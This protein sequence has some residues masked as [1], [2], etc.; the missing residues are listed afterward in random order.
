[1]DFSWTDAGKVVTTLLA[2]VGGGGLIIWKLSTYIGE[3]WA[4]RLIQKKQFDYQAK[5]ESIKKG[6][7]LEFEKIKSKYFRYSENQFVMYNT[8][9]R[10]LMDLKISGEILY[11]DTSNDNLRTFS[12]QLNET[13]NDILKSALLIENE[14]YSKLLELLNEF[15]DYK[16]GKKSLIDLRLEKAGSPSLN[17]RLRE[18][19]AIFLNDKVRET[20]NSLLGDILVVFR[21]QIRNV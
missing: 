10:T 5:L 13:R 4:K 2:S 21:S 16:I 8:L 3:V 15:S 11:M 9:W 14:P 17:I 19:L 1:M 20:Y 12:E 7:E 6:Y 18:Q